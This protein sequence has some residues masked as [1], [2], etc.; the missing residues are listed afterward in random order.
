M[1]PLLRRRMKNI[2][3]SKVRTILGKKDGEVSLLGYGKTSRAVLDILIDIPE[4]VHITVYQNGDIS[5]PRGIERSDFTI[6]KTDI[7]GDIVFASPSVRREKLKLRKSTVITSDTEM[8]FEA[9]HENI[10]L[11]TGSDG[12][13]TVSAMSAALLNERFPDIFLGG[14]IG[15]P[16][17]LCDLSKTEASVI[18]LSSFNLRYTEPRSDRA[19]ITNI[20]PNHLNWHESYEEYIEAK[21]R[22]LRHSSEPIINVDTDECAKIAKRTPLY[23]VCSSRYSQNELRSLYSAEHIFTVEN[24]QILS[25]GYALISTAELRLKERH[26]AVNFASALALTHG[27]CDTESILSV[28]Q[29]FSGLPHRCELFFENDGVAFVDSSIDTTPN[30]TAATLLS[31]DKRVNIIL[32]GRGKGL[33]LSPLK[34]P[35]IRYAKRISVYGDISDELEAFISSDASLSG[36]PHATFANFADAVRHATADVS[37]GDTVLLSPAATSY[38]E[39]LSFEQR[40]EAFRDM[41]KKNYTKI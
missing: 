12:K 33:D 27:Y 23:A 37:A 9:S 40:G 7:K 36:I 30:R 31:L 14:N 10:F 19:I 35:L 8:F 1:T 17:A 39:F 38:G 18:E 6:E 11:V 21:E 26:N 13:S 28:A 34:E 29:T 22:I 4:P 16:L 2:I 25:D 41:I 24:G 20:T 32:G 3:I 5:L 15:T